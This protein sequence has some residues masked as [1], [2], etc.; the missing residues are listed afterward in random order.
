[1]DTS[2]GPAK[3]NVRADITRKYDERVAETIDPHRAKAR[4]ILRD[5]TD[6]EV[7][8]FEGTFTAP[9]DPPKYEEPKSYL[10]APL[11]LMPG[12][13]GEGDDDGE[14]DQAFRADKIEFLVMVRNVTEDERRDD[15]VLKDAGEVDW[16]IPSKDEFEDVMGQVF[17]LFMDEC[18]GLVHA[19]KWASVGSATGVGCF[20]VSTG[21]RNHISDIRGI[22]C[23]MIHNGRCF[24]SFPKRAMM[25]SFSLTAFFPR[26]TKFVGMGRLIEWVFSCNRGLKGTI[27]PSAV[28]KFPDDHPNPRKRGAR[29]LSFTGDQKFLDSLHAFPRGFPFSVKLANVYIQGGNVQRSARTARGRRGPG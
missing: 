26:A 22:M 7:V 28:K 10:D 8:D 2:S 3:R 16:D 29:I 17:D 21:Q 15:A 25:K 6:G 13:T 1:M 18:P 4:D 24:E 20:S 27:W 11:L 9:K 5:V 19:F 14:L 12:S 23:T